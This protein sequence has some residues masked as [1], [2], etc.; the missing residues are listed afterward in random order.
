MPAMT[1]LVQTRVLNFLLLTQKT[2]GAHRKIVK[3]KLA[4]NCTSFSI[5]HKQTLF[6]T[7]PFFIWQFKPIQRDSIIF[8]HYLLTTWVQLTMQP[9][10]THVIMKIF[11][12]MSAT[13]GTQLAHWITWRLYSSGLFSSLI[14]SHEQHPVPRGHTG[15]DVVG[16]V[17]HAQDASPPIPQEAEV[18]LHSFPRDMKVWHTC[19]GLSETDRRR[20]RASGWSLFKEFTTSA[21]AVTSGCW[22]TVESQMSLCRPDTD[23]E[24]SILSDNR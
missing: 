10:Y 17:K 12:H 9:L 3:V 15:S 6:A 19:E 14:H 16:T 24:P 2:S 18:P 20:V 4:S 8:K 5:F 11:M 21:E 23:S 13:A 1:S 22:L 7:K